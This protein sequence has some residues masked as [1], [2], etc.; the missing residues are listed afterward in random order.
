[1]EKK[2]RFNPEVYKFKKQDYNVK[3]EKFK[4][5]FYENQ[6]ANKKKI[7]Q[8]LVEATYLQVMHRLDKDKD[9]DKKFP[10]EFR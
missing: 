2:R 8:Q 5:Q 6:Y 3:Q 4:Q 9:K 7:M 10:V 1:M